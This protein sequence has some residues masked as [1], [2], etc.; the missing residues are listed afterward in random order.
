[1]KLRKRQLI[2]KTSSRGR[3]SLDVDLVEQ[4][5]KE[6]IHRLVRNSEVFVHYFREGGFC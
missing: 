5:G 2:F 3:K 1:M 6:V 4:E